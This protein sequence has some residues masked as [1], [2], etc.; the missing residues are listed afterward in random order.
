MPAA[1]RIPFQTADTC[2]VRLEVRDVAGDLVRELINEELP[3]GPRQVIW[4]GKDDDGHD[5]HNGWYQVAM[6]CRDDADTILFADTAEMLLIRIDHGQTPLR[7]GSDGRVVVT[8]PTWV[9]GFW[10]LPPVQAL[11]ENGD[12]RGEFDLTTTMQI[13]AV[14][15]RVEFEAVEGTQTVTVQELGKL[16]ATVAPALRRPLDRSEALC[17]PPIFYRLGNPCP[18]P[19]N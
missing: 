5:A 12:L 8:D 7:T 16:D 6:T 13:R 11:D 19:F 14:G 17:D 9:P 2:R 18:N 3:N 4:D 15:E 1:V 10:D